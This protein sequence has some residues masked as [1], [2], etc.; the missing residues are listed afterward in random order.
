MPCLPNRLSTGLGSAM[1]HPRNES[2]VSSFFR[3]FFS[4]SKPAT[5][6][7]PGIARDAGLSE[8]PGSGPGAHHGRV[9]RDGER[10][11]HRASADPEHYRLCL[12]Y[13]GSGSLGRNTQIRRCV[14]DAVHCGCPRQSSNAAHVRDRRFRR[15]RGAPNV[16][17]GAHSPD[18]DNGD[19]LLG[20]DD[21]AQRSCPRAAEASL[22]SCLCG[23]ADHFWIDRNDGWPPDGPCRSA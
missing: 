15:A 1:L 21:D 14:A 5:S 23:H 20:T 16:V 22:L 3:V 11:R 18:A 8:C 19:F 6:P 4:Q 12:G 17:S 13:C 9:R 7:A 10:G 2:V